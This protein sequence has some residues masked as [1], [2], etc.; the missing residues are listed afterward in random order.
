VHKRE[1]LTSTELDTCR[2]THLSLCT[3]L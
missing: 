3:C 2:N 1:E